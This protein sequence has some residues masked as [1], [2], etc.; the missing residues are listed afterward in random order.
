MPTIFAEL[1][2]ALAIAERESG[3]PTALGGSSSAPGGAFAVPRGSFLPIDH[4][5]ICFGVA[6]ALRVRKGVLD[7]PQVIRRQL[8]L[9]GGDVLPKAVEFGGSGDRDDP[10]LLS[11][12]PRKG[13]LRRRRALPL[14]G[15]LEEFDK[16][17]VRLACLLVGEAGDGAAE[18]V[19][20]DLRLLADCAGEEALAERAE[21]DEADAKLF[22]R[23]Q[24][25]LL[26]LAPPER[27]LRLE[28]RHRLHRVRAADVLDARLRHAEVLDLSFVD[29]F[30]DRSGDLFDWNVRVDAVLVVEVD[31]VGAKALERAFDNPCN[32]LW[33]AID[34]AA[35]S[36]REV[37]PE[38]GRDD[39]PVAQRFEGFADEFLVCVGAVA[40]GGVEEG[41]ARLDRITDQPDAVFLW[42]ERRKRLAEAHATETDLG[43]LKS[44]AEYAC[45]HLKSS[46]ART[47]L[48]SPGRGGRRKATHPCRALRSSPSLR[49]SARSRTRRGSRASA[50]GAPTSG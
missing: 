7:L 24:D 30:L 23:R 44:L 27:I 19:A 1:H 20:S 42:R 38:L 35:R 11:E 9:G 15:V 45:F 21:R 40:L 25:R 16:G 47:A 4:P 29:E 34:E 8:D 18:V 32:C 2:R 43:D 12:D 13:D 46:V 39:D 36:S 28:G 31:V 49:R 33:A 17:E 22:E 10:R 14:S 26:G 37:P 3:W 5:L 41:D 48:R 50:P 6:S